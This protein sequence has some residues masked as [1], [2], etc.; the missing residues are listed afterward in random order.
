MSW[1][2]SGSPSLTLRSVFKAMPVRWPA[3]GAEAARTEN[4]R[5]AKYGRISSRRRGEKPENNRGTGKAA[6][7]RPSASNG[8]GGEK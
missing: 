5:P 3:P 6:L 4:P 1:T 7:V 8:A 2:A